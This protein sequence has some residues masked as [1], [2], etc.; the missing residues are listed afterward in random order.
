MSKTNG[1]KPKPEWME[2]LD[3][4]EASHVRL[5]TDFEVWT[6]QHERDREADR[7]AW[8]AQLAVDHAEWVARG[9]AIDKRIA[10]L[11]E[12]TDKR[13]SALVAAMGEFIARVSK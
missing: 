5:M 9:D 2:R 8:K 4:V 13:I 12:A 1:D 10:A 7:A 6:R 11:G 3:R